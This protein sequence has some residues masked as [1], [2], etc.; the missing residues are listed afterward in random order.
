MKDYIH[1]YVGTGNRV[2]VDVK[3][4]NEFDTKVYNNMTLAQL[5]ELVTDFKI[6]YPIDIVITFKS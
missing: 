1:I 4:G 3:V 2:I 5:D 6:M